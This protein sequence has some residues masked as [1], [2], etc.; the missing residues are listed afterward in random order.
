MESLFVVC[1]VLAIL[2]TLVFLQD[3]HIV[4][5]YNTTA[6]VLPAIYATFVNV[7]SSNTQGKNE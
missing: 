4:P 1:N 2:I 3:L 5:Y 6:L 7:H